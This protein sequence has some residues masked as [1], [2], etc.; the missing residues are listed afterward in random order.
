MLVSTKKGKKYFKQANI[1]CPKCSSRDV[2]KNSIYSRKLIFLKIREQNVLFKNINI[3]NGHM[4]YADLS[5][6]INWNA[7]IT[8]L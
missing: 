3:I 7:N 8:I 1:I 4:I 2:V 6:I 5:S